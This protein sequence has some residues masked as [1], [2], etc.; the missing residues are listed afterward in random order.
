M[1]DQQLYA[2]LEQLR[3][4]L[5]KRTALDI[6]IAEKKAAI[7]R[8]FAGRRIDDRRARFAAHATASREH[9]KPPAVAKPTDIVV[10][11]LQ[12]AAPDGVSPREMMT[13]GK[14]A[15]GALGLLVRRGRVSRLPNGNW[16]LAPG[17][18]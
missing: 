8:L 12:E 17:R 10:G 4:A 3:V 11:Y 13:L 16:A 5:E 2:A 1:D 15:V 6:E 14:K 18:I 7:E 9:R